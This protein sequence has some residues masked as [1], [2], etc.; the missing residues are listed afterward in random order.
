MNRETW[1]ETAVEHVSLILKDRAEVTVPSVRVAAGWPSRG[2]TS[3]KKRVLGECWRPSVAADSVS[4]IYLNPMMDDPIQILGVLT[5]ELIH[6]VHPEAKHRG[7]FVSTAKAVG[8]TG[9]WTAT[10]VGVELEPLLKRISEELGVYPHSKLTPSVQRPVQTTRM[11]KIEC[12]DC[13]YIVRTTQKWVDVGLPI[14]ACG[15][16]MELK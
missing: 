13:G 12:I 6:A 7:P 2:G 10:S 11:L 1:L 15:G 4:Q 14:C 3:T 9:P 5:H 8:L 16:E